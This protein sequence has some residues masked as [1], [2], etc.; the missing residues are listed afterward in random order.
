MAPISVP[1][2]GSTGRKGAFAEQTYERPGKT[3]LVTRAA[4]IFRRRPGDAVVEPVMTGGMDNPVDVAFTPAGERILTATF[5]EHPQAGPARRP[6]SRD[7]RRRVRKAARGHRRI[8]N[9]PAT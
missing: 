9:E 2:A 4:H 1:T 8:T 6:D 7:L 5:L 3:P